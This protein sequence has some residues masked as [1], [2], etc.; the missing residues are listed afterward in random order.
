MIVFIV[1]KEFDVKLTKYLIL[2]FFLLLPIFSTHAAPYSVLELCAFSDGQEFQ[3]S[4]KDSDEAEKSGFQQ[5]KES[6]FFIRN[7]KLL[8]DG[9]EHVFYKPIEKKKNCIR[10]DKIPG[11]KHTVSLNLK[12]GTYTTLETAAPYITTFK[13]GLLHSG[14]INIVKGPV[15]TVEIHQLGKKIVLFEAITDQQVP[16]CE[17]SCEVP[18]GV[19]LYFVEKP[20]EE[21]ELCRPTFQLVVENERDKNLGCYDKK[22]IEEMLGKYIKENNI[23]CNP[24]VEIAFFRVFGEGCIV[25]PAVDPEGIGVLPPQIRIVPAGNKGSKYFVARYPKDKEPYH[26]NSEKKGTEFI[27][28][29]EEIIE[30]FEEK[31][32]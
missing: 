25:A 11:G 10:V 15:A 1:L 2:L 17:Y 22:A 29:K 9:T 7:F 23:M 31:A 30:F 4:T 26:F 20:S 19:P 14:K 32:Q 16:D 3:L 28:E 21:K 13:V 24:E 5:F 27:P 8:I 18:T 12:A 6:E